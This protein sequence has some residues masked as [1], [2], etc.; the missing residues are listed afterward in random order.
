MLYSMW[1]E[2]AADYLLIIGN[3]EHNFLLLLMPKD[4]KLKRIPYGF[5]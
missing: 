5:K 3:M 2:P 1:L 4:K